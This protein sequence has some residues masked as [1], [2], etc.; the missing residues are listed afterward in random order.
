MLGRGDP[1]GRLGIG[2]PF[3][4]PSYE[5]FRWWTWLVAGGFEAGDVLLNGPDVPGEVA[6]P[7]AHNAI[8]RAFLATEADTL[9]IVE[10]DHVGEQDVV[11]R[12][13]GKAE[14]R[15]YDIVCANYSKRASDLDLVGVAFTGEV[16]D[17]GEAECRIDPMA[18][19]E[20]GTQPVDCAALGLVL[21]RRWVLE[22]MLGDQQPEDYH[23][24]DW[25]GHN[26]QDV[27]FY[28][29]ARAVG[30]RVAVDRDAQI[31]HVGKAI[32]WPKHFYRRRAAA[33]EGNDG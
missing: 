26:S 10:D 5:F 7:V 27:Q 28:W 14:N 3:Y 23:W 11:Q 15:D 8:V 13:R 22:E 6:I 29:R 32:Y 30:A 24:F 18:A 31:G 1:F 12:M 9:C 16:S 20:T 2:V 19:W 4:K 21:I 25:R 33:T 17:Y